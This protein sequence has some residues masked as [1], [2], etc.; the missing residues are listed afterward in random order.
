M[1]G[2]SKSLRER[3]NERTNERARGG[4]RRVARGILIRVTRR[5]G[6]SEDGGGRHHSHSVFLGRLFW[7]DQLS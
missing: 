4:D 1:R 5:G 3:T 6:A 7:G 2:C